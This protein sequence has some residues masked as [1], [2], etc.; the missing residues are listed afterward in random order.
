[1]GSGERQPIRSW[2]GSTLNASTYNEPQHYGVE[3]HRKLMRLAL[4]C[5]YRSQRA[6][7]IFKTSYACAEIRALR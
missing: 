6:M 4:L 1:M 2:M 3:E 5:V 7:G